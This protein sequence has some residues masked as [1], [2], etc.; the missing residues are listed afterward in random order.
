MYLVLSTFKVWERVIK[1]RRF[2]YEPRL[3]WASAIH[4]RFGAAASVAA[5]VAATSGVISTGFGRKAFLDPFTAAL[6]Q[7]GS[8]TM[9]NAGCS[10]WFNPAALSTAA[11]VGGLGYLVFSQ[12][13]AASSEWRSAKRRDSA[14]RSGTKSTSS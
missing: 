12:L 6:A 11:L 13:W 1:Q 5:M 8:G 4:R 14:L 9:V 7:P 3:L 10:S 2:A